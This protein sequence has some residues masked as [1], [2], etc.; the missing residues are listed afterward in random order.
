MLSWMLRQLTMYNFF[1]FDFLFWFS[2][3]KYIYQMT[4][5]QFFKQVLV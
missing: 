5:Q 1:L 3:Q 2:L 4:A